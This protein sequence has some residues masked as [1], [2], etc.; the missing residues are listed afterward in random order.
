M[1][2]ILFIAVAVLAIFSCKPVKK[3]QILQTAIAKKD[4]AT[5]VLVKEVPKVDS[6]IIV[7][8]ILDKT[9]NNRIVFTT[10]DAK[11]KVDYES[12]EDSKK[13]TAY[14]QMKK[15][16]MIII[17]LSG[18]FLGMS[19]VGAEV[20]ITKDS[21]V[22]LNRIDETVEYQTISYLQD[23]TKIPFDFYTLQD[24]IIG[25]P[26]FLNNNI[27]SYKNGSTQL[28]VLM[29]GSIFKHLLTLDNR[30]YK[31]LH[32]KLDDI[33]IMRNRSCDIS[34]GTYVPL[35][36]FQFATYRKISVAEKSEL[37]V[38]LD[39]KEYSIN[40]PLKYSFSIPKKYAIK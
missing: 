3:V 8:N 34:F 29:I 40:E 20:K 23:V 36:G 6:A 11:V 19:K 37:D 33:D 27:V 24:V 15:D 2:Y 25:N 35:N 21:V 28:S 32:S 13:F 30:D 9:V 5:T 22:I 31:V 1:R 39:F 4:T 18:T 38:F 10:F 14:F 16:S 7:K 17:K 12:A 26:V